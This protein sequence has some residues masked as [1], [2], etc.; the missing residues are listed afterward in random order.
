MRLLIYF[1]ALLSGVNAAEAARPASVEPSAAQS[2]A[3]AF[4]DVIEAE[5]Q[6]VMLSNA[7]EA[8]PKLAEASESA[9]PVLATPIAANTPVTRSD[10][11]RE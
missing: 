4:A 2:A 8:M 1:L 6:S 7:A 10:I 11:I 3:L 9:V 5:S